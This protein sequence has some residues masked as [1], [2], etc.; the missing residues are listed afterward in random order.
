MKRKGIILCLAAVMALSAV[1]FGFAKWS[2][3]VNAAVNPSTG[4]LKLEW[5]QNSDYDID[6]RDLLGDFHTLQG[7]NLFKIVHDSEGK[8]VGSTSTEIVDSDGDG[9][10]DRLN[11]TVNDAYPFY[12]NEVSGTVVNTGSIPLIINKD[13]G[14]T[15]HWMG[16]DY[17]LIDGKVYWLSNKGTIIIPDAARIAT[18]VQVGEEWVME[19]RWMNNAG[20]QL[21]PGDP[22]EESF[23][24]QILQAAEQGKTYE[25]GFSIEGIQWNEVVK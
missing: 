5:V 19:I 11:I 21:H 10:K 22:R 16:N 17:P 8:E 20:A 14:P 18:P 25:F 13:G 4:N 1:G 24:F 2:L 3:S 6:S 7:L 23:H 15:L 9:T 12:Y